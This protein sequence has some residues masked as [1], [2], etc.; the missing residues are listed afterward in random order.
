MNSDVPKPENVLRTAD[1]NAS[2]EL[3]SAAASPNSYY[4]LLMK[5]CR[6]RLTVLPASDPQQTIK[7]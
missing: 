5:K 2:Q 4:Q 6:S 1:E 7:G 3:N